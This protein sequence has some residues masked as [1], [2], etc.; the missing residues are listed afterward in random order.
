MNQP[1]WGSGETL[2]DATVQ[3]RA[4]EAARQADTSGQQR[5]LLDANLQPS[6][7]LVPQVGIGRIVSSVD[8]YAMDTVLS[9]D[10]SPTAPSPLESRLNS[11]SP[12]PGASHGKGS[13]RVVR[14]RK[15]KANN[16]GFARDLGEVIHDAKPHHLEKSAGTGEAQAAILV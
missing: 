5:Q 6:G 15:S 13:S 11:P 16:V 4:P 12:R 8:E 14:K 3:Q 7:R 1:V 9:D 2:R 10:F